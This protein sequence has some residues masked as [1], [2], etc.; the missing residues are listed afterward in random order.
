MAPHIGIL[1]VNTIPGDVFE[2]FKRVETRGQVFRF[3]ILSKNN[4]VISPPGRCD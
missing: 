3:S 2:E 1:Y 4:D